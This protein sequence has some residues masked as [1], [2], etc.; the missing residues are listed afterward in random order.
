MKNVLIITTVSGFLEKFEKNNVKILQEM[1][2]TVH[3]AANMKEQHYLYDEEIL[4]S[5]GVITHHIDIEKSPYM[6]KNNLKAYKQLKQ[7]VKD[8]YI[9]M[10]HCHTPVGGLLGRMVGRVCGKNKVKTIYTAHG[11]HFYKGAPLL[12]VTLYKSVEHLMARNTDALVLI[13]DEDYQYGKK[14][15]LRK[16]GKIY[17]IPGIGLDLER[18]KPFSQETI[19]QKR[20]ELNIEPDECMIVSVGELNENKNQRVILE[21]ME[22]LI[23]EN[24]HGGK[25]KY[26]ICGDGFYNDKIETWINEMKLENHVIKCGYQ[27]DIRTILGCADAFVFPSKRE[28]LGMAGLEAL[29][30]GIPAV[31][32]DNR[33][34]KEY[35]VD[36]ENGYV[37]KNN[38]ASEY[39]ENIKKAFAMTAEQKAKMKEA[40]GITVQD[41]EQ[42]K[43]TKIMKKVYKE[44]EK[45]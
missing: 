5:K 25:I 21:A 3:Y 12:N 28:G 44:A 14:L 39:A 11:F 31:V 35:I 24:Y 42:G 9:T 29:A 1:G 23:A 40:C 34:T 38:A 26:F 33:G 13:N 36:G 17:K 32:A 16:G 37:C 27:R 43:T 8:N 4:K 20:K 10:L 7:I 18:F 41:F 6:I 19:E 15:R 2:Y 45:L 30:M 22:Q